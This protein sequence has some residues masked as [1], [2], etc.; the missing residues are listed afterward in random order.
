[1]NLS[2]TLL[3][4]SAEQWTGRLAL[5]SDQ[6]P[7]AIYEFYQRE[8]P[9]YMWVEITAVRSE[10]SILTMSRLDR[11]ATL[12]IAPESGGSSITITVGPLSPAM[13]PME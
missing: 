5:T 1:M 8:M 9:R 12:M 6:P 11:V 3:I 2:D 10:V 7:D 4:G 13:T